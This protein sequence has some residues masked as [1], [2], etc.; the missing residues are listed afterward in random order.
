MLCAGPLTGGVDSC[1]GDSGGP[2]VCSN[3]VNGIVSFGDGCGA[4]NRPGVY[5]D[6]YYFRDWIR[7][8]SGV[9]LSIS[10][11][12]LGLSVLLGWIVMNFVK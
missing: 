6:V 1:Q 5:S 12:I 4:V 9:H 2:L 10:K 11:S 8:N 7:D 3:V